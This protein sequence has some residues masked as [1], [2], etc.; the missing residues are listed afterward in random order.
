LSKNNSSGQGIPRERLNLT[1]RF[2]KVIELLI[3][4]NPFWAHNHRDLYFSGFEAFRDSGSNAQTSAEHSP[5]KIVY[6]IKSIKKLL[7]RKGQESST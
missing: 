5:S 4:S 7:N 3:S 2:E 1:A 6:W